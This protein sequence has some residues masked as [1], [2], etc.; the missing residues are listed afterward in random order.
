V[1]IGFGLQ[2]LVSN[3]LSGVILAFERPV[4][5]GDRVQVGD[6]TGRMKQVGLRA[7]IIGTADGADVIVPNADLISSRVT[8]WSLTN[9]IRRIEMPVSVAR[10]ADPHRVLEILAGV[11]GGRAGVLRSP[12]PS[13]QFRGFGESSLDFALLFWV[14]SSDDSSKLS[15]DVGLAVHD[16]LKQAGVE[17]PFPQREL[18]LSSI[19]PEAGRALGG[20]PPEPAP[21]GPRIGTEGGR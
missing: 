6:L 3:F 17:V 18:H 1:G 2:N 14:H 20:N 15:S 7:S 9:T 11:A 8:N 13:V 10:E 19:A 4:E 16:A 12:A 5:V 21:G